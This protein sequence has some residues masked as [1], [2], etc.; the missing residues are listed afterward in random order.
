MIVTNNQDILGSWLCER[1]GLKPTMDLRCI[2]RL[3]ADGRS[4]IGVVGFDGWNGASVQ[5]HV[6]GEGNWC[7]RSLLLAAFD[8]P[9][10][11][12]KVDMVLG[13]VPSGNKAALRFNLHI[14]FKVEHEIVG[15]HPDGSLIIVSMTRAE[16]R[17][18]KG[19]R[20]GQ[21]SSISRSA[22]A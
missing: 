5:M 14:G 17:W 6:A 1:I 13:M 18:L 2:G 16:C 21:E 11:V 7:S 22:A 19:Q 20:H 15:A 8:Y 10:R 4:I 12:G 9:F 3:S